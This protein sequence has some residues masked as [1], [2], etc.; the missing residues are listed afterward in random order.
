MSRNTVNNKTTS[1]TFDDFSNHYNDISNSEVINQNYAKLIYEVILQALAD[2]R[3]CN[4]ARVIANGKA[5]DNWPTKII[6]KKKVILAGY[7]DRPSKV[8]ELIHFFLGGDLDE[9][10]EMLGASGYK[11]AI[12][13]KAGL[14]A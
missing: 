10:L 9:Y 3:L 11:D 14:S 13:K 1:K 6:S 8:S 2:I 12:T 4:I 7:Y 5:I